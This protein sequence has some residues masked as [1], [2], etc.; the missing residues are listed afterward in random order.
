MVHFHFLVWQLPNWHFVLFFYQCVHCFLF[1]TSDSIFI[2]RLQ[3]I[4]SY[5]VDIKSF[6]FQNRSFKEMINKTYLLPA[7]WSLE[8]S[9]YKNQQKNVQP[10]KKLKEGILLALNQNKASVQFWKKL[11]QAAGAK[12]YVYTGRYIV[13]SLN[14]AVVLK[15]KMW[16]YFYSSCNIAVSLSSS[17]PCHSRPLIFLTFERILHNDKI[18]SGVQ[19]MSWLGHYLCFCS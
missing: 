4:T 16:T 18:V 1:F 2:D 13:W 12:V 10:F 11:I 7:G 15:K 3:I 14:L 17:P 5:I 19:V 9:N 8:R 6:Y